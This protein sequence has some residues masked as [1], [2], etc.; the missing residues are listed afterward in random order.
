MTFIKM[1]EAFLDNFNKK[2]A[3]NNH[4]FEVGLDKDKLWDLYLNAF[5]KEYNPLFRERTR[6]D[7]SSCRHF[8]KNF[9]NVVAINPDTYE[10]ETIWDVKVSPEYQP[11]FDTMAEYIRSNAISDV[12]VSKQKRI[13][14][15][16]NYEFCDGTTHTFN[17]FYVDLP[18][19]LIDSSRDS[20]ETIKGD[21]RAVKSV[22]KRSLEEITE[23]ATLVVLD[24]IA[25]NSL[26][27]GLEWQKAL[28]AF[29]EYQSKYATIPDNLK[30][31]FVWL[32]SRLAGT[33]ITK[34][35]NHSM[36]TLLVDISEGKDLDLAV[37]SYERIVAPSNYKRPK[38]I[39]T[40]KMLDDAKKTIEEM[41]FLSALGRKY[42][43]L[44]DISVNNI[45]F[46]NKDSAKRI[47]GFDAIFEDM[48]KSTVNKPKKFNKVEEIP[49]DKFVKDVLPT[50][51]ELE[52]YLESKHKGNL[53]SLIAPTDKDSK[54]MFKWNNNFSWAYAGNMTDSIKD[55]VKSLGGNVEGDLRFS[56]QWNDKSDSNQNDFDAHCIEPDGYE[57]YYGNRCVSSPNG[58]T[59]D[60]DIIHPYNDPAVENI[61]YVSKH[62]MKPG[63]Y[64]FFVNCFS[65]RGGRDG[66]TAEIEFD[67][68]VY[69]FEYPH[70]CRNKED[71][72]IADVVVNADKSFELVPKL[73]SSMSSVEM[74]GLTS[75][76]FIPASVVMY[77]P[78]YWDEQE[79][80]GNKHYFFMLKECVNDERPNGF[81]N[82]FLKNELSEHKRVFAALGS[83]M[84]VEPSDDQLSGLG[85]SS[86]KRDELIVKVK[87]STERILKVKF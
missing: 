40:Q 13:G 32:E 85:F 8:I 68:N 70:S 67:G 26:Y 71:V 4:L 63:I 33:A 79:G 43:T 78:N 76:N 86:T 60:V 62:K 44:D 30:S 83:R 66:F 1:R 82:E 50:A 75:N 5:P 48:S 14:T 27:R 28:N 24:L 9:G 35:R 72:L 37:R 56:I 69:Q 65:D 53:V 31:N 25:D 57:L 20:V 6:H 80:V 21:A 64:R 51:S 10:I 12:F 42:A 73:D 54:T 59:L 47:A 81:Y 2:I 34:I 19:K 7:C 41:G 58:G 84:K 46:S 15:K 61:A 52:V 16:E 18:N 17:H 3:S 87:G 39:F 22:F 11:S 36:G 23:G 74:W 38:E 55:R 45:L 29:A 49:I 77:S